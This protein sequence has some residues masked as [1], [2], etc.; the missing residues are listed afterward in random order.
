MLENLQ[1]K[2]KPVKEEA[3]RR[4]EAV[5]VRANELRED[6]E[7]RARRA[8]DGA[9]RAVA[10]A[11][12]DVRDAGAHLL[13]TAGRDTLGAVS[14]RIGTRTDLAP[15][16]PRVATLQAGLDRLVARLEAAP[17]AGY[18]AMSA[19]DA[20]AAVAPMSAMQRI[21]VRHYEAAHKARVTVLRAC[22]VAEA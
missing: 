14:E 9:M 21:A 15:L 18:D 5:V 6:L 4:V 1:S 16:Q 11:G 19:K 22:D 10:E 2:L 13:A 17:I 7:G 3:N 8:T 12:L 20:I